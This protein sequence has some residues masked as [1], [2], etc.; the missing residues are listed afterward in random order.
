MITYPYERP[1]LYCSVCGLKLMSKIS[2]DGSRTYDCVTGKTESQK[3]KTNLVCPS[4]QPLHDSFIMAMDEGQ[5][6]CW[7]RVLT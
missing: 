3:E 1:P 6:Y 5:P 4:G 7:T 2:P